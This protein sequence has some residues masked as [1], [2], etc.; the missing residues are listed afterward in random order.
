MR[1][2]APDDLVRGQFRGYL[3]EPGVKPDS[4][5]DNLPAADHTLAVG[6]DLLASIPEPELPD[7]APN[8]EIT[9]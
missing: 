7:H 8:L 4:L 5:L 9:P 6:S 3:R 2:L 1:T